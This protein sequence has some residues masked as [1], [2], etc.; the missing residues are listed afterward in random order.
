MYYIRRLSKEKNAFRLK[1]AASAREIESD[2]LGQ[3][4][5]TSQ[6][7]LSVWRCNSLETEDL[8][9]TIKAALFSS[10]GIITTKLIVLCEDEIMAAGIQV[11]DAP[12]K[13][14]Y[15]GLASL[16]SNFCNLTYERIGSFLDVSLGACKKSERV[17]TVQKNAFQ[18]M[19]VDAHKNGKLIFTEMPEHLA[20]EAKRLLESRL[21]VDLDTE[22]S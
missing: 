18:E 11:N 13:T 6:N 1:D 4:L 8:D 15:A 3:E 2:F 9:Q 19:I 12:G 21:G 22:Y 20:K 10:N 5:R 16:H 17:L 14:G 7:T